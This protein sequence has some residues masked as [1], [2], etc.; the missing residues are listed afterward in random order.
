[1]RGEVLTFD[2]ATGLGAIL[3]DDGERHL[4]AATDVRAATPLRR[5]QKVDFQAT[6]DGQAR[7]VVIVSPAGPVGGPVGGSF[8]LARVI[9]RTFDAIARQAVFFIGAAVVLVGAPNALI[10]GGSYSLGSGQASSGFLLMAVGWLLNFVGA[11]ALQGVVVRAAVSGFNG[12][13]L[14]MG[15]ALALALRMALPLLGLVII[16]GLGVAVGYILLIVP[17]VMLS[18]LWSVAAPSVVIE[19]RGV[20]ESLQRSRELTRGH[21]WPIFGLLVIFVLGS[22]V[23]SAFAMGLGA[24]TGGLS[25]TPNFW[26]TVLAGPAV[27]A[28][29]AVVASAGVAALYYELRTVKE[30]VGPEALAAV[31]D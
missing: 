27:T 4:V 2:E 28:L 8:D 29:S 16:M 31:F 18:V 24:A 11:L 30:G 9:Q 19:G 25:G 1:M 21:R 23:A 3:G 13:L 7:E 12:R 15:E 22:W 5:G 6:E 26:V 10:A 14:S 17:G 20:F